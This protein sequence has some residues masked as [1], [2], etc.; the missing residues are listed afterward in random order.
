MQHAFHQAFRVGRCLH[1]P[2]GLGDGTA[3]GIADFRRGNGL[4]AGQHVHELQPLGQLVLGQV[5]GQIG[6]QALLHGLVRCLIGLEHHQGLGPDQAFFFGRADHA[7]LGHGVVGLQGAGDLGRRDELA[8]DL[9]Q[10]IA[11]AGIVV[12][13]FRVAPEAVA[14]LH[15]GAQEHVTA[16]L[17]LVPVAQRG[18]GAI[19]QQRADIAIRH[20]DILLVH[21]PDAEARHRLAH[22]PFGRL[23]RRVGQVDVQHLGG[24]EA[25]EHGRAQPFLEAAL[26]TGRKRVASRDAQAQRHLMV[27]GALGIGQQRRQ[28]RRH[29]EQHGRACAHHLGRRSPRQIMHEI[30]HGTAAGLEHGHGTR[31]HGEDEGVAQAVGAV[32]RR[33]RQAAVPGGQLQHALPEQL[34]HLHQAGMAVDGGA[35][36][37]VD[38]GGIEPEAGLIADGVDGLEVIVL[39]TGLQDGA[40]VTAIGQ[41]RFRDQQPRQRGNGVVQTIQ[42][43]VDRTRDEERLGPRIAQHVVVVVL[44]QPR[45]DADRH[46]PRLDGPQEDG[47]PVD[48]VGQAQHD[49][50]FAPHPDGV[51]PTREVVHPPGQLAIGHGH[52]LIDEGHLVG[53]ARLQVALQ[54]V[55]GSVVVTRDAGQHH[56][57]T[58]FGTR[59]FLVHR[60]ISGTNGRKGNGMPRV[61]KSLAQPAAAARCRRSCTAR[62]AG[63]TGGCST[64]M[65]STPSASS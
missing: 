49:A 6:H 17:T 7:H 23:R 55:V 5:V 35:G 36:M 58:V 13:T 20:V 32:E 24:T 47:R 15:P 4:I 54:Q 14:G 26:Q 46:D 40:D 12:E 59:R 39:G 37:P 53:A 30:A 2:F 57:G 18:R 43:R 51:Q 34:A 64:R 8:G 63:S 10:V 16:L 21:Q 22:R 28:R 50:V 33:H 19:D 45:V 60:A 9:D 27:I 3:V 25:I 38:A 29:A 62:Q 65:A 11:T 44:G 42:C 61:G 48:R 41:R 56:F 52:P 31:H 1:E